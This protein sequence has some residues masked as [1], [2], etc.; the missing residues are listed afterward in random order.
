[1]NEFLSPASWIQ[2]FIR[3]LSKTK[4]SGLLKIGKKLGK[5]SGQFLYVTARGKTETYSIPVISSVFVKSDKLFLTRQSKP[6][7]KRAKSVNW[8]ISNI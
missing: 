8:E 2:D 4:V 5:D 7:N 1:M 3:H 6:Q